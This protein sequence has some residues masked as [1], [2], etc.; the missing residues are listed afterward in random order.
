MATIQRFEDLS[1]WKK[2]RVLTRRVYAVSK[3]GAFAKDFAL[4]DQMRR[5]SLSV[6]SNIA[7]G[8]ERETD[9]DFARFLTI[10]KASTG[11]VRCQLYV[12]FDE[13][14]I[15]QETFDKLMALISETS[16]LI[17]GLIR[18]LRKS[19]SRKS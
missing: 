3:R 17:A 10:A 4:R 7:E 12:A 16:R 11:E 2:A 18:Y 19:E 1:S 13:G 8:F 15:D 6:M 14:Y 5:A 9:R